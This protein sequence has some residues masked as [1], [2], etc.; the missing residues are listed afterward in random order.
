MGQRGRGGGPVVGGRAAV[1]QLAAVEGAAAGG[2]AWE[3]QA[4][5]GGGVGDAVDRRHRVPLP[6]GRRCDAARGK[7]GGGAEFEHACFPLQT[8]LAV[9][10]PIG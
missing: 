7:G 2:A 8:S 6:A 9:T 4:V 3:A 10:C 1:P 5:G